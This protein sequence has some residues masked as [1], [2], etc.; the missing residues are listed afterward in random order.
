MEKHD[1]LYEQNLQNKNK[2]GNPRPDDPGFP[3]Y[4]HFAF[5]EHLKQI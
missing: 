2:K 4:F 1:I 5:H 3:F